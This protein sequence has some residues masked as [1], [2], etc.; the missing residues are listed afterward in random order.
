RCSRGFR[1]RTTATG[2][3]RFGAQWKFNNEGRAASEALGRRGE[4]TMMHLNDRPR[5]AE[6][7]SRPARA[8]AAAKRRRLL[9]GLEDAIQVGRFDA[10]SVI[11]D[12]HEQPRRRTVVPGLTYLSLHFHAGSPRAE[13]DGVLQQVP[14]HLL[15]PRPVPLDRTA[16]RKSQVNLQLLFV[17]VEIRGHDRCGITQ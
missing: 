14:E 7:Q 4:A 15:E 5:N 17:R 9:E 6:P 11:T 12:P 3:C 1:K 13:L 8:A 2:G 16:S 10:D